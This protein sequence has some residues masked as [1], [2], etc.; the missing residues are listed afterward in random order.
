VS[1]YSKSEYLEKVVG[2][3]E[4]GE[5]HA[6]IQEVIE[7]AFDERQGWKRAVEAMEGGRARG[8]VV[9]AVP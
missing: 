6:E 2:L 8:K 3:A 9:L 1:L 7:G 4:R 5:V